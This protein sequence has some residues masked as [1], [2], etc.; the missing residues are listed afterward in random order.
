MTGDRYLEEFFL[1]M[2]YW[3]RRGRVVLKGTRPTGNRDVIYVEDVVS[4]DNATASANNMP[5]EVAKCCWQIAG[6]IKEA[7]LGH[8]YVKDLWHLGNKIVKLIFENS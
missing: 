7:R 4:G 1:S 2:S 8:E 6:F 5:V 3:L